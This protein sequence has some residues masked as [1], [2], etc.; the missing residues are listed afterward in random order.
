[1]DADTEQQRG[2]PGNIRHG[3]AYGGADSRRQRTPAMPDAVDAVADDLPHGLA[4]AAAVRE[5]AVANQRPLISELHEVAGVEPARANP[6][7]IDPDLLLVQRFELVGGAVAVQP[8]DHRAV[9]VPG[10]AHADHAAG[11][12]DDVQRVSGQPG[13]DPT[14][15]AGEVFQRGGGGDIVDERPGG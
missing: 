1:D 2:A 8:G 15:G 11:P 10:A 14:L 13:R 7:A 3:I 6:L 12:D 5:Q 9:V 4:R